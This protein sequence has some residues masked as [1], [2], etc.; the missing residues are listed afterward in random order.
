MKRTRLTFTNAV[1]VT[2]AALTVSAATPARASG[3]FGVDGLQGCSSYGTT[4][5][6]YCPFNWTGAT[7]PYTASTSTNTPVWVHITETDV[8]DGY[9]YVYGTCLKGHSYTVTLT[10][11]DS[12][13]AV[14]SGQDDG[15]CGYS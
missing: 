10:L 7:G 14:G 11:Q 5:S 12:T 3:T 6:F 4:S 8:Y 9:A 15:I 13:G 1:L 2:A